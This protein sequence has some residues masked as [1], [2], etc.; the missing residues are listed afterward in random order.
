MYLTL[1]LK[2]MRKII[3]MM[4]AFLCFAFVSFAQMQKASIFGPLPDGKVSGKFQD[5]GSKVL[6]TATISLLNAKDSSIVKIA[7]PLKDGNFIFENFKYGS[8]LVSISASG[9]AKTY[10]DVFEVNEKK[11]TVAL[12]TIELNSTAK[13][14]GEVVITS[15]KPLIEQK[16]DRMVINVD[17]AVTN[18]G[19]SALE[20]L[21]K[22]PGV[23]VDKDGNISLKGKQGV[24]I[25][26]DGRPT[27][28]GGTDLTNYLSNLN[29][30]QLDIIE[31]MT[32]PP[33]KYDAAGNSGIIN[34]KTKKTKQVGYTGSISSSWSQGK[35]SR[36]NESINFN[37]RKN[38]INLFSTLS[39]N[40]RKNFNDIHIQRNFLETGTKDLKSHFEQVS[41][42]VEGGKSYNAKLGMDFYAT[43]KTTL[44]VV[45]T[46]FDNPG[47][48]LNNSDVLIY[49]PN[50]SL[51]SQ[52][53]AA[54]TNDRKWNNFSTNIN[55]R[56]VFDS[57]GKELTADVDFLT[58]SSTNNQLLSN[59]YFNSNGVPTIKPDTLLGDLPQDINIYTAKMDYLHPLKKGAKLEAGIKTSFV[60]TDNNAIYDSVNYGVR[61]RDIGRSNHFI[62]EENVNAAYVN[63]SKPISKKL[64]GQFGLRIENTNAKGNQV[65]SNIKFERHYSQVFPTAFLQYK[66]NEKNS[67]GL[68]Y[69]KRI[70]RPDYA[71]LN[72][73]INFLDRYTYEQGNPNL[74][75]QFAH[76]VELNHIFKGFLTTTLNYTKTTDIINQVLEQNTE[77]NET[78]VKKSNIANSRQYGIAINAGGQIKKWWTGNLYANL[79]NNHFSG[80]ING[81][82]VELGVTSAQFNV[83]NQFKFAKTWGAEISGYY[84]TPSADGVF[85][86]NGFGIMNLG[87]NK[88]VLK[89]KGSVRMNVRDVLY[90]QKINGK[91]KYSNI[92]ATFQQVRDSRIFTLG[93]SY[94]FSKGKVNGQKR[95]TGGAGD[96]QNRVKIGEN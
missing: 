87:L 19:A 94:R 40:K 34:I 13:N 41:G 59:A 69:G 57:T 71:D 53:L 12:K 83:S 7:L 73:F 25:Y 26:I 92:D 93:F 96:E 21:E 65:I 5:G 52:T 11:S 74:K 33:A 35:Y 2:E 31:I 29:S 30:S 36:F 42:I 1:K 72:P 51:V 77:K 78:Y 62:Y 32:N 28:L 6:E 24:Q 18:V 70:Q 48:F 10:S 23:S 45:F 80:I 38:K 56:H 17:A 39:Y 88:Q 61:V 63:Y 54:T 89:G 55:M 3:I 79:Y 66:P 82:F 60:K 64:F 95:K 20:V 4:T 8:Y 37:Y 22:S 44:G 75:P 67:F 27:Y 76:N 84:R 15:K 46:G 81:D 68:N 49:S 16:I 47:T 50:M 90:T 91:I 43:K 14:L 85:Q 58:Y 86:I 9:H